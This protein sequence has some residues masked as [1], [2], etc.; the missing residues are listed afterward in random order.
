MGAI[1]TAGKVGGV[2]AGVSTVAAGLVPV[3]SQ[4]GVF[5]GAASSLGAGTGTLTAAGTWIA[6]SAPWLAG[7]GQAV[8]AGL[9][10]GGPLIA[11]GLVVGA[12]CLLPFLGS[13]LGKTV[14]SAVEK[15]S[16]GKNETQ[17]ERGPA[18]SP[19]T[20]KGQTVQRETT[21]YQPGVSPT[22]GLPGKP[23]ARSPHI[24]TA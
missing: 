1:S 24:R 21:P 6:T 23:P 9:A 2:A 3:T 11:A 19:E 17:A 13:W 4:L 8:V 5:A 15:F 20:A 12:A 14:E 16:G 10:F 18:V 22:A 7:I